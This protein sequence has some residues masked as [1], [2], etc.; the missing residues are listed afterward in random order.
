MKV[1]TGD[2]FVETM[3]ED[4]LLDIIEGKKIPGLKVTK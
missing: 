1:V 2:E 4:D 3:T